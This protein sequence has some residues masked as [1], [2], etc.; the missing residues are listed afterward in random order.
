MGSLK[1]VSAKFGNTAGKRVGMHTG[2][3]PHP[4]LPPIHNAG[5]TYAPFAKAEPKTFGQGTKGV[6]KPKG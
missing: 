2:K 3:A 6:P 1:K 5:Y 4:P